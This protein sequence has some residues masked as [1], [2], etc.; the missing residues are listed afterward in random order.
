MKKIIKDIACTIATLGPI[1]YLPCPGTCATI[2]TLPIVYLISLALPT[3]CANSYSD[4]RADAESYIGLFNTEIGLFLL[5]FLSLLAIASQSL[6]AACEKLGHSD[7][8]H[9]VIDELI[10]TIVAF[11]ALPITLPTVVIGVI[12]FRFFD[13]VKPLGIKKIETKYPLYAAI[14]TDDILA[15]VYTNIAMRIILKL[16]PVV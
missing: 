12:L 8:P 7:S 5:L 6:P 13:I 2:A 16:V 10:G 9:I 11:Y 3:L 15:G 14:L 1:G 4:C